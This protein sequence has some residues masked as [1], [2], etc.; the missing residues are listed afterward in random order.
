MRHGWRVWFGGLAVLVLVG[1]G[2]VLPARPAAAAADSYDSWHAVYTVGADGI[3]HVRET[4]V[5]RFDPAGGR[6]GIYRDYTTREAWGQTDQDAVYTISNIAVTSPDPGVSTQFTTSTLGA[7]T[8]D[9]ALE[10]KI[11]SASQTVQAP[12]ATYVISYDVAGGMRTTADYDEFYWDAVPDQTPTVSDIAITVD[13]PGGVQDVFCSSARPG[14]SSTGD[15]TSAQVNPDGS[16]TYTVASKPASNIVTISAKIGSGLVS[17]NAPHLVPAASSGQPTY[18][19]QQD[20]T[21]ARNA[22]LGVTGGSLV[23]A[24]VGGGVFVK[25]RRTD[26]RFAGVAPGT[27]PAAG[28]AVVARDDHPTIPVAFSPPDIPVAV[29]GLLDDGAVD[30]RDTTAALMS[31]A[32]RGAIQLRQE[33]GTS[34]FLG[35]GST[36]PQIYGKLIDP[37]LATAPH[38]QQLLRDVF[39]SRPGVELALSAPGTLTRAHDRMRD[40]VRAEAANVGMYARMPDKYLT[41]QTGGVTIASG[42]GRVLLYLFVFVWIAGFLGIGG[43]MLTLFQA[44]GILIVVGP[45][46]VLVLAVVVARALIRRGQRSAVGRA[47]ADQITGFREYLTTA[48]A[49]QIKFEEGQDIF[50]KY[51]PW[52]IIYGVADRWAKVCQQLVAEGRL[53]MQP[54]W[55]YGDMRGFNYF[56]LSNAWTRLDTGAMPAQTSLGGGGFGGWSSAGSGFGGGSAFGGGGFGGGGGFSGG[57]GGGGGAGGW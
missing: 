24:L 10:L 8:R 55:Y 23:A 4:L 30:V 11:G 29:A 42:F 34:G 40:T 9:E 14:V 41:S 15:C 37:S 20:Q 57:G 52:A 18:P 28:T 36:D 22:G 21:A 45:L 6:H 50:S 43:G 48:E 17:D 56:F 44:S 54:T 39:G 47:F 13:V 38:E 33:E 7:G 35:L 12:T 3:V 53:I 31:L 19:N 26:E 32:V 5:Y 51:L 46:I 27:I 16:A 25:R 49:D 2:A 1:L